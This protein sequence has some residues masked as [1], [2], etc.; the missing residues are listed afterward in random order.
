[1]S[2]KIKTFNFTQFCMFIQSGIAIFYMQSQLWFKIYVCIFNCIKYLDIIVHF[3]IATWACVCRR[4][5]ESWRTRGTSWYTT[6]RPST[7]RT[8]WR[9]ARCS[10]GWASRRLRL[11]ATSSSPRPGTQT[12]S[13]PGDTR[14]SSQTERGHT[15]RCSRFF[16]G[17]P[18]PLQLYVLYVIV[19]VNV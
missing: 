14:S 8:W 16:A 18:V 1:M 17:T 3:V 15:P 6:S 7:G 13:R 10:A 19:S 4:R 11:T 5:A 2:K 9:C 12:A